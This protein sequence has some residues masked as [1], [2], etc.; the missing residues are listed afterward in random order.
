MM[1]RHILDRAKDI[2]KTDFKLAKGVPRQNLA[3][4][5][6]SHLN[7]GSAAAQPQKS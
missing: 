2:E 4:Q 7:P 3:M 5:H 1:V 6:P